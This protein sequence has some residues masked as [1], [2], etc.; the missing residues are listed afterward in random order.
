MPSIA[1]VV[2]Q[3]RDAFRRRTGSKRSSVPKRLR[4]SLQ[5]VSST[6]SEQFLRSGKGHTG[7]M[8]RCVRSAC[9]AVCYQECEHPASA[10]LEY[11]VHERDF[12]QEIMDLMFIQDSRRMAFPHQL[13]HFR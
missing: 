4:K 7:R 5:G 9:K 10:T 12:S 13:G 1:K 2:N 3:F 8:A 11:S 6:Y